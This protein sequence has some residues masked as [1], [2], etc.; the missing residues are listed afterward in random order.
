MKGELTHDKWLRLTDEESKEISRK[1]REQIAL[2]KSGFGGKIPA[3][4]D[5]IKIVDIRE[6]SDAKRIL[7]L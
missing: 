1:A 2:I 6:Y 5:Y 7:G 3:N 4:G